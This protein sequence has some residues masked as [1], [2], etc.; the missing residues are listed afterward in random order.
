[1]LVTGAVSA[2]VAALVH[3]ANRAMILG[4]IKMATVL[5]VTA[6]AV[7]AGLGVTARLPAR[8]APLA[9]SA[10]PDAGQ[11]PPAGRPTGLPADWSQTVTADPVK[12]VFPTLLEL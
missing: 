3:G 8:A 5:L 7:G 2:T 4:K 12:D 1:K 9:T 6:G 11:Q 10:P